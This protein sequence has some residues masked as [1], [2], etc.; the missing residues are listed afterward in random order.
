MTDMTFAGMVTAPAAFRL[1][2][3]VPDPDWDGM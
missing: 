2:T 1:A 3:I